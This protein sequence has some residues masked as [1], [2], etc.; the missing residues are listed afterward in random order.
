MRFADFLTVRICVVAVLAAFSSGGFALA[1]LMLLYPEPVTQQLELAT[2]VLSSAMAALVTMLLGVTL[3]API[4]RTLARCAEVIDLLHYCDEGERPRL[5]DPL[6]RLQRAVLDLRERVVGDNGVEAKWAIRD[7][8]E[9]ERQRELEA[10]IADF[11]KEV[12]GLVAATRARFAHN[13]KLAGVV[14]EAAGQVEIK[15]VDAAKASAT[16]SAE[17]EAVSAAAETVASANVRIAQRAERARQFA[18]ETRDTSARGSGEMQELRAQ[19]E[20]ITAVVDIIRNVAEKTN[21][22]ALN[23][24]IEAARAGVAGRGF[25]VVA[26]QVKSLAEQT[27]KATEEIGELVSRIQESSMAA[28]TSFGVA[29]EALVEVEGLVADIAEAIT[30]QDQAVGGITYAIM[31][32]ASSASVCAYDITHLA[33]AAGRASTGAAEMA[34]ESEAI[35]SAASHLSERIEGFL[36]TVNADLEDRRASLRTMVNESAQVQVGGKVQEA[37]LLDIS[38]SGARVLTE[39]LLL[40]GSELTLIRSGGDIARGEVVWTQA[41]SYGVRFRQEQMREDPAVELAAAFGKRAA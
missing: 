12:S 38:P 20:H 34:R 1:A 16:S 18:T 41:R 37:R 40:P 21:L 26:G 3:A 24:S 9:L 13:R 39:A 6:K 23:A 5:H 29:L 7:G 28:S 33:E 19:A 31:G 35:F 14:E 4:R 32:A 11:S 22:L 10:Q 36:H 27:A 17:V 30:E 8:R 15:A 25:A 2:F